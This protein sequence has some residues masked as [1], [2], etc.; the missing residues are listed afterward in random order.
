[1]PLPVRDYSETVRSNQS[2]LDTE[3]LAEFHKHVTVDTTLIA[4]DNVQWPSAV[5]LPQ[6]SSQNLGK[7]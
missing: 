2:R 4:L 7:N 5:E 1:M 3:K 6:Q